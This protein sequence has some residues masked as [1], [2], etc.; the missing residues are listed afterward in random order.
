MSKLFQALLSGI[1]FTFFLDYFFLLG[2]KKNYVDKFV[3]ALYYDNFFADTQNIFIYAFF[4]LLIGYLV[5]YAE[6]VKI[7][8]TMV[9]LL[10]ALS[11]STLF[12]SVGYKV[13]EFLFL[14]KD[15]IFQEKKHSFRGDVYY[16]TRTHIV[17][18]DYELGKIIKLNK[19]E[20]I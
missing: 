17:F 2:V 16:E 3:E 11:A 18:Y 8:V 13:G 9:A 15:V 20:L 10:F 7:K 1:F 5:I 6:S 12:Q 19:K 14:Q 4:T